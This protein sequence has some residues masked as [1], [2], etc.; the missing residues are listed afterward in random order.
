MLFDY[1]RNG[2]L[3]NLLQGTT[4]TFPSNIYFALLTAWPD[5]DATGSTISEP[6]GGGYQRAQLNP[7]PINYAGASGGVSWN[8]TAVQWPTPTGSWNTVVGVA[9]TDAS[10]G[11]NAY[12]AGLAS[13]GLIGVGSPPPTFP[14]G[15]ILFELGSRD[16]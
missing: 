12:I 1:F 14:I 2:V 4:F 8:N 16:P 11:G 9:L 5:P 13:L 15:D 3:N 10:N 7:S 6:S